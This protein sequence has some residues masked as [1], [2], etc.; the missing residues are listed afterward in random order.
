MNFSTPFSKSRLD[1]LSLF[2]ILWAVATIF[3]L[4]SFPEDV[5]LLHPISWLSG[6]AAVAVFLFPRSILLL[7]L[8]LCFRIADV[9]QWIPFIP[10]HIFFEFLLN[11]GMLLAIGWSYCKQSRESAT[12]RLDLA[13]AG[14]RERFFQS[15]APVARI[16]LLILYFFAVLH[17]LN[18]DYLNPA[19]SC[20]TFLLNG[21]AAKRLP[22]LPSGEW[23]ELSAVWGTLLLEAGIPLMLCFRRTRTAGIL[24]GMVFHFFLSIHPH[25]G[26]YSF[27]ALMFS[28]YVLFTPPDFPQKLQE[29]L[30][31]LGRKWQTAPFLLKAVG[32]CS[33]PAFAL[34]AWLN[35]YDRLYIAG[36]LY[37][38]AW[39]AAAMLLFV[40][41][42]LGGSGYAGIRP[43]SIFR[44]KT[45]FLWLVP[46]LLFFNG[47]SPYL[48][49]KT[50]SSFSMF[51][52]L[53][54]EGGKT[55]HLF[56][57]NTIRLTNFQED[58]VEVTETDAEEFQVL[59]DKEKYITSFEFQ[60]VAS[61]IKRDF[62]ALYKRNGKQD[63]LIVKGGI[64]NRPELTSPHS[65]F[66][67]K[68]FYFRYI[69]KEGPCKC[70][71]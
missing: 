25:R 57:P 42:L 11:I 58:L 12:E 26:I 55:N 39:A 40:L 6:V 66:F 1:S 50:E 70:M 16:S 51:S 22:F 38:S 54:T 17:K 61:E 59:L 32:M 24:I 3:H 2:S 46:A 56:M 41:V 13:D 36:F 20:G 68:F 27:S 45:P 21:I 69:D 31:A 19:S 28:L 7:V 43:E 15:F 14:V 23:V 65:W 53:R 37:W 5:R 44:I 4:L 71:H 67:N 49:L 34:L 60:R 33:L 64:S 47:M 10:N 52:N 63:T 48:G 18:W 8:L 35:W 62:R 30:H 29:V 9:W